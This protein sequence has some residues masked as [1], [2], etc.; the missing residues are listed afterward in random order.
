MVWQERPSAI[1][2]MVTRAVESGKVRFRKNILM[3]AALFTVILFIKK[4]CIKLLPYEKL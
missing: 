2:V 4:F 1:I 3:F